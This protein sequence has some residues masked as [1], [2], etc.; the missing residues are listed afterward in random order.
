MPDADMSHSYR[1]AKFSPVL[2][3]AAERFGTPT[4]V[5]DMA[6]VESAAS[7]VE[8]AF[9]PPWVLQYSLKA[10]D[11]PAISSFLY[12]RGWG[13]NVVST[14]EWQFARHG[15]IRNS[16]ITFE[17]IGKTDAQLEFAV[18]EAADGRPIRWLAVES[19]EEAARLAELSERHQLGRA[20]RAP[21]DLLLR[22]N[23]QVNPETRAEFA[24]GRAASKF[25]MTEVQILALVRGGLFDRPGL[26]LRGIHVHTGSDLKDVGAWADAGLRA[27]RL[28]A[29]LARLEPTADTVDYGGGFPQA[30]PSAP[31]PAR[32]LAALTEALA[33]AG[34]R[35]PPRPAIEPGRFLVGR[36]GWLV[37]SV[38]HAR[39]AA[40]DDGT[41]LT[42]IDAGLTELIRPA[43]YGSRHGVY[44]LPP[45]R[46]RPDS[47]TASSVHGP[48]CE[49]TDTFGIHQLPPLRRGDI[50][51]IEDA[52]AYGASF[53]S[54]YNGRPAPV[55]VALWPDGSLERFDRPAIVASAP[56]ANPVPAMAW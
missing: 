5:M 40:A 17:G 47:V 56:Q 36:A 19:A 31:S 12:K 25:G 41:A 55:E 3:A 27:T 30:A 51:A 34:L 29:E 21:L 9:R 43:L 24:V 33:G 18:V 4:Y 46:W 16:A 2:L 52:G 50:V 13:G 38:L 44:A 10:N 45:E 23:P 26:R 42:V 49:S 28:L 22:L 48:I 15:G 39:P 8:A 11:L 1:I 37:T 53:T 20:G 6:T 54:R 7:A 32:F 14:G 35:L